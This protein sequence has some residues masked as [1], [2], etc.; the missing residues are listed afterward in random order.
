M[1]Q[2]HQPRQHCSNQADRPRRRVLIISPHFPP[3]NAPDHQR[4]RVALPYLEQFG[5]E[6][7][8]LAVKA[9]DVPHPQDPMLVKTLPPH[10]PIITV[11]ALPS[12]YTKLIGL[13]GVGWRCLP[14]MQAIGDRLLAEEKF[15]L[16][17]FSTTIFP[18]M[19]LGKR[20]WQKFGIPYVLDFQDPW[21]SDYHQGKAVSNQS[22]PGGR[23][24]YGMTQLLAR[25]SEPQAMRS[26]QEVISVS[27]SYPT[28]LKNRYA[29][30]RPEQFTILPF[31]APEQDFEQLAK[32]QVK[33]PI[34]D[35]QDGKQHWVYVG[36]GGADMQC[37]LHI[38]FTGIQA[39]RLSN[40]IAWANVQLHFVGTSYAPSHLAVKTIEPIATACG[41]GD[42]VVEHTSRIPY[43]EAQ[44][45]LRDSDVIM[46][47]GSDDASYT[48]SKLYSCILAQKP[49]LAIFHQNSSV[50]HIL[51]DCQAGEVIT[52]GDTAQSRL[53][54]PIL[55]TF[56]KSPP[57]VKTNWEA[58]APYTGQKM[59]QRLCEV[60]D[61]AVNQVMIEISQTDSLQHLVKTK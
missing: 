5:W 54:A 58:F 45:L 46:M 1:L 50:V 60:F 38:L 23:L 28:I 6:A 43:F 4:I 21:R 56:V 48:A 26:V 30:L 34:F 20:W 55:Q 44:Q 7:T 9:E 24:K 17:F 3:T 13:G 59:T 47:I 35:P 33:Q 41:V 11:D 31:G 8:V 51:R 27:P 53:I 57:P 12:R 10:V 2:I 61:R 36:R 15:D 37:A 39:A 42:M 49:I 25:C 22:P 16:V 32:L 40:P 14:Q 18:V 52:F 19:L 29:W